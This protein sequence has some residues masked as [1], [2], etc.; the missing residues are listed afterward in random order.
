[1]VVGHNGT[2]LTSED[3]TLLTSRDTG[4][5]NHLRGIAHGKN[6]YVAVG[7]QGL[8]LPLLMGL[9]GLLGL[10]FNLEKLPMEMAVL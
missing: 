3:G 9:L 10:Q 2:L 6:T 4:T 1:M 5:S 7:G 8:F